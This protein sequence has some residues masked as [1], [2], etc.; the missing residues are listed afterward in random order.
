MRF[1]NGTVHCTESEFRDMN[2]SYEG[3][4]MKC[5]AVRDGCEPDARNYECY[6]CGARAVYGIEELLIMG[7][8]EFEDEPEEDP[9]PLEHDP[10]P[11][12]RLSSWIVKD[13][14]GRIHV[15]TP[16]REMLRM[17]RDRFN[18]ERRRDPAYRDARKQV[19][20]EALKVHHR[21]REVY[22]SVMTGRF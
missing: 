17:V 18:P 16:D 1:E 20:R 6:D 19:Y 7:G 2:S 4:C 12:A 15:M 11:A 22:L 8:V 5:G 21:N 14:L 9:L 10:S 3:V 13:M